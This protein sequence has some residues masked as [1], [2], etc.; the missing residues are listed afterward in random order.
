VR[1]L[2]LYAVM[3][4]LFF[5][6]GCPKVVFV[7]ERDDH[8]QIYKMRVNG[9]NQVNISNNAF[10]DRF[11]DVSHD[12]KRIVFSSDRDGEGENI[13]IM[14]IDGTNVQQVTTGSGQRIRPRWPPEYF[15]GIIAFAY[16]ASDGNAE[17]WTIK[18]DG[19]SPNKVTDPGLGES[20]NGGHDFYDAGKMIVFSR[21][22]GNSADLY[23]TYYDGSQ[24]VEQIT[25]TDVVHE[26]LPTVSHDGKLLAF[27]EY[28]MLAA[29]WIE[30]IRIVKTGTWADHSIITM[31]PPVVNGSISGIAFSKDDDELFVSARSS[32][33]SG[34]SHQ[35]YEIFSI[36][37]DG[38][39]QKRLTTNEAADYWPC[40]VP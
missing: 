6:T 13:F 36:K 30:R 34:Q 38:T 12:G 19:S 5:C 40:S 17:I 9:D 2:M 11:P 28:V 24:S 27:R 21:R 18:T 20:D 10:A 8:P 22:S 14:N 26:V 1:T 33:V 29:G 7:S 37:V 39:N 25:S 3:V 23:A 31:E 15:E 4:A 16:T 35:R 32:D